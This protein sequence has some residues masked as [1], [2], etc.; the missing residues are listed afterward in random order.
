M[1]GNTVPTTW[2]QFKGRVIADF[3]PDDHVRQAGDRLRKLKQTTSMSKYLSGFRSNML[4]VP[5]M[6]DCEMWD[7]FCPGLKFESRLEEM[8]SR[9][10]EF[11]EEAKISLRVD[12][13]IWGRKLSIVSA[14]STSKPQAPAPMEICNFETADGG[15]K[16]E[17]QRLK[18]YR[19]N[20]YFTCHKIR[21][22]PWKHPRGA[23]ENNF[24]VDEEAEANVRGTEE[25]S[26]DSEN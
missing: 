7:K 2:D 10:A 23:A 12:S 16:L 3:V 21:C 9:V 15:R 8:K 13:A 26:D 1:Q 5:V 19:N 25:H 11:E 6:N 4:T 20:A 22:R 17:G 18:D 14:G 24:E